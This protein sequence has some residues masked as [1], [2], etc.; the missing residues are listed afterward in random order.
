MSST[1]AYLIGFFILIVGVI[2]GAYYLHVPQRWI[3][4]IAIILVGIGI[5]A[6]FTRTRQKEPPR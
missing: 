6:A 1:V 2:L 3:A 4:V 5:M